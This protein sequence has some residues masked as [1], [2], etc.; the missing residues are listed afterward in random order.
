MT[1]AIRPLKIDQATKERVRVLFIAKHE[2]RERLPEGTEPRQGDR[3]DQEAAR[4]ARGLSGLLGRYHA[5]VAAG[6][7]RPDR[8]QQAAAERLDALQRALEKDADSGLLGLF[9]KPQR[10]RG[11]YLWG[12]VG[13]GKSMLMAGFHQTLAIPEKRRAHFHAFMPTSA[14][15]ASN[16]SALTTRVSWSVWNSSATLAA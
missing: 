4:G 6:E 13:R 5:L 12:G 1:D 8:E 9:R 16:W 7:L 3:R 14:S 15:I 2:L 11:V 10:P